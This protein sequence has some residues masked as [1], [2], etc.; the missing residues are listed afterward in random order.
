MQLTDHFS[1]AEMTKSE[2]ASKLKIDNTAPA[3]IVENLTRTAQLLEQVRALLGGSPI[4]ISS[5]YRSP[6][7]NRAVGG[8]T[9]S[10]HGQGL[11]ADFTCAGAGTPLAICRRIAAS[12]IQFQQLIFEG[13]WVHIAAP[14]AGA[15]ARREVLTAHFGK[16]AVHY[17]TGLPT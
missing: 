10:A 7:L 3:P 5:G 6:A 12:S 13:T 2:T 9:N 8:A 11:A 14:L 4:L 16:G 17:T 1:L 15:K